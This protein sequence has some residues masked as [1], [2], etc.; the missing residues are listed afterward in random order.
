MGPPPVASP[1]NNANMA[2]TSHISSQHERLI[3]ELLPFKDASKF[4]EW[5]QSPF[6][7]GNWVE[8]CRDCLAK[9]PTSP[10][11][12]KTRTATA[13]RDAINGRKAKYLAYFP[14]KQGW[15]SEDHHVRFII[16]IV[17]DNI[18]NNLWTDADW[19]KRGIDIAKAVY[20]VLSFLRATYYVQTPPT[21]SA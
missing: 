18:L 13:A 3:L 11:P 9:N 15:T 16:T 7:R 19:K 4:H 2:S 21:Y 17:Q 6:V 5:L 10:E 20:E 1:F 12:D 8:F 14:D